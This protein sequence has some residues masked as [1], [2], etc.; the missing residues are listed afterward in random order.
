MSIRELPER[1]TPGLV[2]AGLARGTTYRTEVFDPEKTRA[3]G[4]IYLKPGDEQCSVCD[5]LIE[6][7]DYP[8]ADFPALLARLKLRHGHTLCPQCLDEV[9]DS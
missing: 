6:G 5:R 4:P 1:R 2:T 9:Q 8:G 3:A 7:S